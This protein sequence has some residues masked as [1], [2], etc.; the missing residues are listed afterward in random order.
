MTDADL[1]ALAR[2]IAA[3]M[4][5]DALLD[6]EDV[7]ALLKCTSRYVSEHY[8]KVPGFPPALQLPS[9]KGRVSRP[10]WQRSD[11]IAWVESHKAG[12]DRSKGGRPRR[13]VPV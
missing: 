3:R 4:A 8:A 12:K 2:E 10:R 7:A 5:P 13:A 11:I 9:S 1:Q 6:L